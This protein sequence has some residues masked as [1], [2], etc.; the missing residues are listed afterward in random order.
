VS[1]TEASSEALV[2]DLLNGTSDEGGGEL[3]ALP[4]AASARAWMRDRYIPTS[5]PAPTTRVD[6]AR[7]GLSGARSRSTALIH[8]QRSS[9][10]GPFKTGP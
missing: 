1:Y 4:S 6:A 5:G 9:A 7:I 10:S 3:D 8:H 2:V